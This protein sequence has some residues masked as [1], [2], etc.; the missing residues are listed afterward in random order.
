MSLRLPIQPSRTGGRFRRGRKSIAS[1]LSGT[2][3][4]RDEDRLKMTCVPAAN[5][6]PCD[7]VTATFQQIQRQIFTPTCSIPTCH[8][9]A[10]GEH[11]LSLTEGEAYASLVGI[12]PANFTANAAGL[13]RV[14]ASNPGNSFILKKLRG[15]LIDGEGVQMPRDLK[16]LH[17][18]HIDL[19]E[20]WI[21]AGAPE[22]GFATALGCH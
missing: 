8:N 11:Q 9:V 10:Q 12:A 17:H 19:I 2:A 3:S 5:T 21:T 13:L 6:T 7:G 20:E 16:R 15:E 4:V 1:T 18:L 14:D 22:T